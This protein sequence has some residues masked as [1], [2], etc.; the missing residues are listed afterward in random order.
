MITCHPF[1]LESPNLDQICILV[2]LRSLLIM[3]FINLQFQF[4]LNRKNCLS[5]ICTVFVSHLLKPA[6]ENIIETI[7]S[8]R[9]NRSPLFIELTF[10]RKPS[11]IISIDNR[12]C[13]RSIHLGRPI[14]PV[15]RNGAS[16][17]LQYRPHLGSHM[18][19]SPGYTR[20]APVTQSAT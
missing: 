1:Q 9:S 2:Q 16:L 14:F 11:M 8:Y 7:A 4:H 3:G 18:R 5:F 17:F 12:Y 6:F 15:N 20:E 19:V 13:K 10:C